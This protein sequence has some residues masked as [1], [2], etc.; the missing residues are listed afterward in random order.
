MVAHG[1]G[2]RI[3][4]GSKAMNNKVFKKGARDIIRDGLLPM[5]FTLAV[6]VM[7]VF[8][9]G[10]TEAS[11]REEGRRLLEESVRDAVIRSYA[12]KG[13]YPATIDY[14]E[15]NYGIYIDRTRYAVHY[16]AFAPNRMPDITVVELQ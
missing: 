2:L 6:L 3:W 11:G 13:R 7:I 10:Q 1:I 5:L 9:L 12:V 16:R 4:K 15:E 14:I 8:G